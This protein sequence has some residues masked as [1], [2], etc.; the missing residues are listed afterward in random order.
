MHRCALILVSLALI[1]GGGTAFGQ[2]N[3]FNVPSGRITTP[4]DVFFQ[5][6]VNFLRQGFSNTTIDFGVWD[7]FEVGINL[8]DLTLY[9]PANQQRDSNSDSDALLNLQRGF[10]LAPD[11]H[12]A[13]GLQ[14]GVAALGRS[15]VN[16]ANFDWVVLEKETEEFGF[17]YAGAYAANDAYGGKGNHFG[18][19]F[20]IEY[21]I[22]PE[23][24]ALMGDVL[25]GSNDLSVAVLGG[26]YTLPNGQWQISLG[27]QLPFPG[28][29]N[30]TGVVLEITR[31]PTRRSEGS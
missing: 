30:D 7:E 21:T 16:F 24:F 1:L 12:L 13:L 28:S 3:L 17:L 14:A 2:Q 15:H 25:T 29:H 10:Q 22:I 20:G 27:C 19:M 31:L 5:E 8:F 18:A 26:V 11:L 9:P 4:G 6:Q 23:T